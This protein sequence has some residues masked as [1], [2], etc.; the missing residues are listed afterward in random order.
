M[1]LFPP[2]F[3]GVVRAVG[4][5]LG[6]PVYT[7]TLIGGWLQ[8]LS[9]ASF[10]GFEPKYLEIQFAVQAWKANIIIGKHL[11]IAAMFLSI[12]F[13]LNTFL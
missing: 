13:S 9:V 11:M 5:I 4:V 12:S 3:S 1:S 7:L 6:T 8:V 10:L 2:F